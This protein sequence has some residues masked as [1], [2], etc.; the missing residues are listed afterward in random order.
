MESRPPSI[1]GFDIGRK[2][3]SGRFGHVY[4]AVHTASGQEV[5]AKIAT[6]PAGVPA[7]RTESRVYHAV[8]GHVGFVTVLAEQFAPELSFLI[9]SRVGR[10]LHDISKTLGP[11]SLKTILMIADQ[12]LASLQY[13]HLRG[14]VD[15]DL[16]P[17]NI[18]VGAGSSI[19]SIFLI[20]FGLALDFRSATQSSLPFRGTPA[21]ASLAAHNCLPLTPKDDIESFLYTMIYFLKG[22]LPWLTNDDRDRIFS[23]KSSIAAAELFEGLPEIFRLIF[24]EVREMAPDDVPAYARYRSLLRDLF[25]S[26][27]FVFDYKYDWIDQGRT[28]FVF[29]GLQPARSMPRFMLSRSPVR[30]KVTSPGPERSP[31]IRRRTLSRGNTQL[32]PDSPI[33]FSH[34]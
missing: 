27:H 1:P 12:L 13:L 32:I 31:A 21:F 23:I 10:S 33:T 28:Q 22:E 9:L 8:R 7:L 15:C 30:R 14:F 26:S 11:M 34:T 29:P 2:L 18:C 16:A 5:A 3:G 20:D 4:R 24:E 6:D 25:V 19:N 17:D